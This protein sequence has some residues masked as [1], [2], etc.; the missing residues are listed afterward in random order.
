V[1][2]LGDQDAPGRADDPVE[3]VLR[4]PHPALLIGGSLA[5]L[6]TASFLSL[7]RDVRVLGG[8]TAGSVAILVAAMVAAIAAALLLGVRRAQTMGATVAGLLLLDVMP[9]LMQIGSASP[10]DAR[11][12]VLFLVIPTVIAASSLAAGAHRV[13]ITAALVLAAMMVGVPGNGRGVPDRMIEACLAVGVLLTADLLVRR[14]SQATAGRIFQLRQ[15][16]LT[17]G[18]TGVLNRR[19]LAAGFAGLVRSTRRD[20]TLGLLIVDIDHFKWF[21]DEYGHAAGDDILRRV[22]RVLATAA[23]PGNLVARIGG[24]ELA[25]LVVGRA[26]PVAV[27]FREA[28]AELRPTVTASIGIVD[29][30]HQDCQERRALWRI[31]D[32]ADRALY[33][34]KNTGRDRVCRGTLDTA[35]PTTQPAAPVPTTAAVSADGIAPAM[36]SSQLPGWAMTVFAMVGLVSVLGRD[37]VP[38]SGPLDWLFLLA[39][40]GCLVAGLALLGTTPRLSSARLLAGVIGADLVIALGVL[41]VSDPV[42]KRIALLPLLLT[43]LVV[44]QRLD[45][46]LVVAH[47]VVAAAVCLLA[48]L[49]G[50]SVP[51]TVAV[52]MYAAVLIGS[53][54]LIYG[55]R[56]RHDHAAEDLHRWSVTDPLTGLANRRGLELA[57]ARMSRTRNITVLA[58]DVDDFKAVNDRHGH[59]VGDDALIRLAA[60]LKTVT[61]QGTV[62]GRTGGDEFVLLAPAAHAGVL[63]TKVSRAAALLPVPLSLSVGSTVAAPYHRLSLWQLVAAADAGLT[64]A[65]RSRRDGAVDGEFAG[66][67]AGES[68]LPVEDA[69]AAAQNE[70][71][72]GLDGHG[73]DGAAAGAAAPA[74]S[75]TLRVVPR[76][77][78][79][80]GEDQ[81]PSEAGK[82]A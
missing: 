38:L 45:R 63:T 79:S 25:A 21:N 15:L 68:T 48:L 54:E 3:A 18:L 9:A 19:G 28:L 6:S 17:D 29:V 58:L 32:A 55:L 64:R 26:E 5:F 52:A 41:E 8:W 70:A 11:A 74:T 23:G 42:A 49:G 10:V 35:A 36:P 78:T 71:R 56:R 31:L 37:P 47:H 80:A 66:S 40:C 75:P 12:R 50:L 30:T 7:S 69:L 34:A 1:I 43:G 16:S 61:G 33:E 81:L 82:T 77:S 60:T 76:G 59:A 39:V 44:A 53:A 72:D 24:E 4:I 27:A 62:V 22:C 51:V 13:H 14:L 65:K 57:Y 67:A 46:G 20:A 2:A 73:P